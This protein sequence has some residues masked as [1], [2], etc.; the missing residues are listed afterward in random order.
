MTLALLFS[1][2][3][4]FITVR[5]SRFVNWLSIS[6]AF[7]LF[8]WCCST[9]DTDIYLGRYYNWDSWM[10]NITEPIYTYTM[11]FFNL[12][13]FSYQSFFIIIALL[14]ITCFYVLVRKLTDKVSYVTGLMLVSIFPMIITLQRSSYA[15]C[16]VFIGFYCLF[17][18]TTTLYKVFIFAIFI[19]IASLIHSMCVMYF[20]FCFF[21]FVN[22]KKIY[23]YVA[24]CIIGIIIGMSMVNFLMNEFLSFLNMTNKAEMLESSSQTG[25]TLIRYILAILR[26]LSVVILPIG[27]NFIL[28]KKYNTEIN[29]FDQKILTINIASLIFCPLLYVL[30]DIYRIY[31]VIAIINFCLA[32]HYLKYNQCRW[33]SLL[34]CFNIGY[35]FIYRP[36]FVNVF[37]QVYSNNLILDF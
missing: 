21:Y 8:G 6:F 25:N 18:C 17:F 9:P 34:C 30:H 11:E 27:L 4:V 33:Y 14:F 15:F 28:K 26:V 19:T 32:T 1:L 10:I 24:I 2:S 20:I 7:I 13:G 16:F 31:Y 12:L 5:N 36:Y 35:W 22:Q 37:V 23:K 3:P 29:N